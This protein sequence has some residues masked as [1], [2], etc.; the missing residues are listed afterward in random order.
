MATKPIV[1]IVGRP[2]VGKST[3]FNRLLGERS[4][5]VQDEPGTTRDR[6]Y[7]EA[8]WGGRVFT[9]VDTG[10]LET[11]PAGTTP[12]GEI[13]TSMVRQQAEQAIDEADLIVFMIDAR[14]GATPSDHEVADI[15]RRT[16]KPVVLAANKADS[17]EREL[18]AV[19]FYELGMGDPIPVS[20]YHGY[21]TGDLLDKIVE[22]L[23]PEEEEEEPED[24]FIRIAIVG[25]PNVGK[26]RL[27]NAIL[28]QERSIVSDVPGTTRDPVDTEVKWSGHELLLIDTA[29]IRRRGKV[30]VGIEQW[31]VMRSLRAIGRS[32]LTL[33][34]LDANEG[35]TA[36]DE[37]IAGYVLEQQKG[38][39]IVVNKWDLI[40]KSS[41]TM[42]E[43][44]RDL[45][46]RLQ[47]LSWAPVTFISAKFSQRIQTV[48]E[49]AVEVAAERQKRAPTAELNRLLKEAIHDHQPPSKPG[50]WLKFLYVTQADIRPPTFVFFVNDAKQIQFGYRR[51]LENRLRERFGFGGT[52][53][54]LVFRNRQE[55]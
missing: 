29:G 43:Y 36:Q 4:A 31:S 44:T 22:L 38:L 46:E 12:S 6:L 48:L 52:P 41:D 34:V 16:N 40:E 32:D 33:L 8:E 21:G 1:A 9:I 13:F 42:R 3:F 55:P 49:A 11:G 17:R 24:D 53:I 50:K 51:Y 10:G 23:P 5:I 27:L 28:G 35:V 30:E 20:S 39:V 7:G 54:K 47:Y 14:S 15:L 45:R 37:H 2:N 19:D 25:R 18:A 26:S